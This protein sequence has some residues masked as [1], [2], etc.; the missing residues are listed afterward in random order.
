MRRPTTTRRLLGLAA[1]GLAAACGGTVTT[2]KSD[3][4]AAQAQGSS[5]AAHAGSNGASLGGSSGGLTGSAGSSGGTFIGSSSSGPSEDTDGGC[6]ANILQFTPTGGM[7]ACW[8]CV[9]KACAMQLTACSTDCQC[10][11]AIGGALH[12]AGSGSDA[13]GCFTSALMNAND[14]QA[15]AMAAA[16][17]LN[18]GAACNCLGPAPTPADGGCVQ[19][20]GGSSGGNG[21]C[22]SDFSET[23]GSRSYQVVCACPQGSCACFGPSSTTAISYAGC[24][25]C[26]GIGIDS[27]TSDDLLTRCGFPH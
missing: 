11:A 7:D 15:Q 14:D 5:G 25:D 8:S 12:C 19:T 27:T 13:P 18:S 23:C 24:P 6:G 21:Q 20:G 1:I 10:N 16:C 26:P 3:G 9:S 4:G 17:V 22:T 2:E